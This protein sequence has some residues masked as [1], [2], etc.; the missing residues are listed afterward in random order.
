MKVA[1]TPFVDTQWT[2][3]LHY[4]RNLFS[5]LAEVPGRPLEPVLFV[6]PGATSSPACELL[7]PFLLRNP[8]T[9]PAW[10]SRRS[11][12]LASTLITACDRSAEAAFRSEGIDLV[13]ENDVWY[14]TRFGLPTLAWIADFQH[15]QLQHMFTPLQRHKRSAKYRAYCSHASGIMVSSEDG[16]NDCESFFPVARGRVD[17]VPFAVELPSSVLDTDARAVVAQHG[18]PPKFFYF[19]AQMWRHKNHAMLVQALRLLKLRGADVVVALSGNA[20]DVFRPDYPRQVLA[21]VEQEGLLPNFR[22]LGHIPYGHI[23]PLMRAAAAVI[24][25]SLFEGWSTT[26][27]E[28]KALGVPLVLSA[29][30]VHRE[31]APAGTRFFDPDSADDMAGVLL[32]AWQSLEPGPRP[33]AERDAVAAYRLRRTA[34][35]QRFIEVAQLASARHP[36]NRHHA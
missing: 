33:Q 12:R 17:V 1:F 26:V 30:R 5:A 13:F 3:G 24:N 35:G 34:F 10:A 25:P 18:L 15:C 21:T 4:L 8:V 16:K 6:P 31:Q 19:P 23:M 29:L 11:V 14:G 27:E 9:V 20:A 28:A 22:F 2:G 32:E 7:R 36:R